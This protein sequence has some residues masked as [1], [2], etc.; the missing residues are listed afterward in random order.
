MGSFRLKFAYQSYAGAS[1]QREIEPYGVAHLDGRW[2]LEAFAAL[3]L[4]VAVP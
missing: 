4:S 1:S 2:Y 3:L